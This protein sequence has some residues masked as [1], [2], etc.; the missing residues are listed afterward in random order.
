MRINRQYPAFIV[1]AG[2][3]DSPHDHLDGLGF[4]DGVGVQEIVDGLVGG[5][6]RKTV[7]Q[8]KPPVPKATRLANPCDAQGRLMQKLHRQSRFYILR[9]A[10][11]PTAQH[12][13]CAKTQMLRCQQP[14]PQVV[15]AD[16]VSQLLPHAPLDGAGVRRFAPRIAFGAM[17]LDLKDLVI[18]YIDVEF[19]FPGR[20][21]R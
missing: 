10:P 11:R 20:M 14:K 1:S 13:P 16:P 21:P 19:F 12:I 3:A 15:A 9:R 2:L 8:F 5:H 6:E 4:G 17:G 7:C 18:S